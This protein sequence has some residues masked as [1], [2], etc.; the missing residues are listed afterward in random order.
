MRSVDPRNPPAEYV[1]P[2]GPE[3]KWPWD[4]EVRMTWNVIEWRKMTP[5]G[6]VEVPILQIRASMA[7]R[8]MV[9][10]DAVFLRHP[11]RPCGED[12][13]PSAYVVALDGRK[14]DQIAVW[15]DGLYGSKPWGCDR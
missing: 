9:A 3:L 1:R 14:F 4:D 10:S 13:D 12:V 8:G 11:C 5:R 6:W 7:E 15:S 2:A